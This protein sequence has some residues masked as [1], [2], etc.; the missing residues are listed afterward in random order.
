MGYIS[1]GM[2]VGRRWKNAHTDMECGRGSIRV[3]I[4]MGRNGKNARTEKGSWRGDYRGGIETFV[5]CSKG[6]P[7]S[8][9]ASTVARTITR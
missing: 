4:K 7:G 2:K 3:G 6:D 5:T 1:I 9:K 8:S